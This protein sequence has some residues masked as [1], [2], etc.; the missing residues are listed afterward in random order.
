MTANYCQSEQELQLVQRK[1]AENYYRW[2][3]RQV[4]KAKAME[5]QLKKNQK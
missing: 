3:D 4:K 1:T 2:L 5:Q